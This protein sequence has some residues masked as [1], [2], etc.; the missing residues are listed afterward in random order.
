MTYTNGSSYTGNWIKGKQQGKGKYV[1]S[2]RDYY[3]G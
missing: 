2:N 3:E 1:F